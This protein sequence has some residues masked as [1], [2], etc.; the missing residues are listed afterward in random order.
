MSNNNTIIKIRGA[1]VHNLKN[2]NLDIPKFKFIVIT[3]VSGSGKSSLA[4]D[5]LYQEGK[6]RYME[7]LSVY[8]RQFLGNFEK[9]DVDQIEGLSPAISIDQKTISHNP[10]STVGT[11]TEIYDYLRVIY[12]HISVP[13]NPHTDQPIQIQTTEQIVQ[14]IAQLEL[15]SKILIMAPIVEQKKGNHQKLFKRLIK[16]GF[17]RV[18]VDQKIL[19]LDEIPLL[20]QNEK[21]DINVIID[22]LKTQDKI[23]SRLNASLDLSLA[24][25]KEKVFVWLNDQEMLK[26]HLNYSNDDLEFTIPERN[27]RL[28]SFNSSL[29]ACETCKGL[30]IRNKFDPKL[31]F[32]FNKSLN[33]GGFILYQQRRDFY[34]KMQDLEQFC[35]Y[36]QIDMNIPLN[37]LGPE[38]LDIL[39]YGKADL[40]NNQHEQPEMEMGV[41]TILEYYYDKLSQNESVMSW[42]KKF[43]I[44][45][46]CSHCLGARINKAALT[47]KINHK[48]IYELTQMS[49]EELAHFIDHLELSPEEQKITALPL[50]EISQRLSFLQDIGL[51]YL[52]LERKSS[53]LSGG[54][55]QRIRLA[56]QI[57]SKLSGVLYVLD[58]PSIGLHQKDNDN[59]ITALKKMTALGNTLLVVE[60][61]KDTMLASDYLIDIGPLAGRYGGEVVAFGTP[62]EVMANP[63]SLTG[64]YLSNQKNIAYPQQRRT[65]NPQQVVYVKNASENNLKRI[66]VVFP[67][68]VFN[69]LT[70]VSG[71]GK[72]TLVNNVLLKN[73]KNKKKRL[74][75]DEKNVNMV[76]DQGYIRRIVEISQ[77]PIGKTPRSNPATY[78]GLFDKIRELY[79]QTNE[80]KT[81][82]YQKGRFSFNVKGGRCERCYGDGIR[83]ISMN[84]L[85]DV[86]VTCDECHGS[87]FRKDTLTIKYKG[88]NIADVLN[89][90]VDEAL[91]F[92]DNHKRIKEHI[93]FLKDVGL[94]YLQLGQSSTT[95]SGGEAQRIK[96]A[97]E[98]Y[99]QITPDT[100][101]ILDEPTTGLHFE[102]IKQLIQVLHRI[103]DKKAT[104]VVIEH[105]LDVIKNADYVIDLGPGGGV[106]GGHIVAQGTP[107]ELSQNDQSYTGYYLNQILKIKS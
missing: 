74:L 87:R 55:S 43:L 82:G 42:F 48:N 9:P 16:D 76:D 78:T 20:N 96:L 30:G 58:E 60:H 91:T 50:E 29:G 72:S 49:I 28:F 106:H 95:L 32:S 10:R 8:S 12:T 59:L 31:L 83:R 40:N 53:T 35:A 38:L 45:E 103:T 64:Q 93:Q 85:P 46:T 100:L 23:E 97:S 7:S 36:H 99:K 90:T 22:R 5:T 102:D 67:L 57:G 41:I 81:R 19:S 88:K 73:L 18:M 86:F 104:L 101:Y 84:F 94:G 2:I 24:L 33:Q 37:N 69:V 92:F 17:T 44:E 75:K 27:M 54:E 107:E 66:N 15:D 52:T 1:R 89:M 6:R 77:S 70:G 51:S 80:A 11:I 4:F 26:F 61:D 62:S 71:S 63:N 98:L 79:A 105:N 21:H 3:G 13:Y 34:N 47:F 56:T 39:L 14:Q 65:I 25:V 68:G